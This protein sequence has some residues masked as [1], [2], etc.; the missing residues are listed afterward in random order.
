MVYDGMKLN[1][2]IFEQLNGYSGGVWD[3]SAPH[4]LA[5]LLVFLAKRF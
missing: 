2:S 3:C 5:L 1:S 4:F